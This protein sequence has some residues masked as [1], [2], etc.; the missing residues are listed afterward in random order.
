MP[1]LK[2]LFLDA[3]VTGSSRQSVDTVNTQSI[4]AWARLD[5]DGRYELK[6]RAPVSLQVNIDNVTVNNYYKSSSSVS[7]MPHCAQRAPPWA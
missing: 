5:I 1:R 2:S 6:T 3:R 7:A 4:P